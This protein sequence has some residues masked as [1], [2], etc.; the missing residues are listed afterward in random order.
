MI[1]CLAQ[2]HSA[3]PPMSLKPVTLQSQV[4]HSATEPSPPPYKGLKVRLL[5]TAKYCACCVIIVILHIIMATLRE[6]LIRLLVKYKGTEQPV[7]PHSLI[8]LFIVCLL[9]SI[10]SKLAAIEITIF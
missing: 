6:N 4:K 5:L 7:F 9:E 2:G 1:K 10:I 8:S 3:V